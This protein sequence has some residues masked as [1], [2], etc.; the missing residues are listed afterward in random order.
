M[1]LNLQVSYRRAFYVRRRRL[2]NRIYL[3]HLARLIEI[4]ELSSYVW[5][6]CDG[7]RNPLQVAKL[8]A[9][10]FQE[11]DAGQAGALALYNISFFSERRLVLPES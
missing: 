11:I 6:L 10:K 8:V 3:I 5:L 9:S 1:D 7:S 4:D 2:K